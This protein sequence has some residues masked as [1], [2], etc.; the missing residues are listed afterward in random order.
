[1]HKP[2]A[3]NSIV[4]D[5]AT[6]STGSFVGGGRIAM[7]VVLTTI[8]SLSVVVWGCWVCRPID[9]NGVMGRR[10]RGRGCVRITLTK[11][12]LTHTTAARISRPYWPE[13]T[14][15]GRICQYQNFLQPEKLAKYARSFGGPIGYYK[16]YPATIRSQITRGREI[17]TRIK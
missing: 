13:K 15:R 2:H 16:A 4:H 14:A 17:T 9:W 3:P 12:T 6:R 11:L 7:R 1:M 8:G 10:G 5:R